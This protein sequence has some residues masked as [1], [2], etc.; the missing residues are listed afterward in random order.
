MVDIEEKFKWLIGME[1]NKALAV[2][3]LYRPYYLYPYYVNGKNFFST[4]N[5]DM[6]RIH[7]RVE[8]DIIILINGCG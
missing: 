5:I 6:N 4:S 3:N 8:N 7:V 1:Y 2:M